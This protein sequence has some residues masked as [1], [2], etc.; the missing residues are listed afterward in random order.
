[1]PASRSASSCSCFHRLRHVVTP[2]EAGHRADR[3]VAHM[4]GAPRSLVAEAFKEGRVTV[5][6]QAIKSSAPLEAG[7]A[8]EFTLPE[9]PRL[10]VRP[11]A[12]DLPILYEDDVLL[13]V[14]K[15]AGMTTHPAHGATS[16]TL[17]N[18]LLAH[19]GGLPGDPLRAGL[20]HRLDRDTSGLLV[21][22]K[23]P[24]ALTVLGKALARRTVQREYLG[25][26]AGMPQHAKGT[27]E[28]PIGRDP[29][30]R[31]KYAVVADGKPAITHYAL[32]ECL[33]NAAELQFTLETGRTH[34]IRV[35]MSTLGH[36]LINDPLYG[37]SDSRFALP[38]Q[39]LH[40]WRLSF[41]HPTARELMTF[42]AAPPK[43]YQLA[44]QLLQ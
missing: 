44:K 29:R 31:L 7:D 34:Q 12:I 2:E 38:G 42:E 11:E 24:H 6:G 13:V 17:V 28:G 10:E 37:R 5:G 41:E 26:V 43:E 16:G 4:A 22:A 25:L 8:I 35:H 19:T 1:M 32:R 30:N 39:A 15:P 23:T 40:A 9:R 21:V 3:I 27:V 36:P 33:R 18:A 14:D 20:V